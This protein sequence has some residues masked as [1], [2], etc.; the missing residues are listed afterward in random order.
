MPVWI[1]F[2]GKHRLFRVFEFRNGFNFYVVQ[3]ENKF[4][5]VILFLMNI[6]FNMLLKIEENNKVIKES[7]AH[8]IQAILTCRKQHKY[9]KKFGY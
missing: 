8:P 7:V 6:F 1:L 4:T 5:L 3:L 2:G 9:D